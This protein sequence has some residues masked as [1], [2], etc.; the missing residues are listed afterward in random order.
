MTNY[1]K[2]KLLWIQ[3]TPGAAGR[4]LLVCCTTS[5][6]VGNWIDSPLPDPYEF[7]LERFCVPEGTDHMA[8]EPTTPY[9]TKWYTRNVVFDRGDDLTETEAYNSLLTCE[10]SKKHYNEN[11]MIANVWHKP[12][13]PTWAKSIKVITICSD[14]QT[15]PWL[16]Q[17]R[18]EILYKWF[19]NK[20]HLLK[21]MPSHAPVGNHAK[22][23]EPIQF[24]RSYSNADEFVKEDI[25]KELVT[26]GPGLNINL[27]TLLYDD[28][29]HT[30]DSVDAYLGKPINRKWCNI[31]MDTWRQRW[32]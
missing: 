24:E 32:V 26:N 25:K 5:D 22:L 1:L 29:E 3:Y 23:Y 8:N 17:R 30:W 21:Y 14:N 6:A 11:K 2:N 9:D 27:S 15:M 28:L 31:L 16:L 20:V 10:L 12:Y 18:K 19:E 4:A 7:T 13:I